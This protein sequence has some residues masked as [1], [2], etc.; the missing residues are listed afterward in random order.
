MRPS[1][2]I[3]SLLGT[4]YQK[5]AFFA[6][7]PSSGAFSS[8]TTS[9]PS[10]RLNSAVGSAPPP[11]P[12]TITSVTTST[13]RSPVTGVAA[14]RAGRVGAASAVVVGVWFKTTGTSLLSRD[15]RLDGA[16]RAGGSPAQAARSRAST[17]SRVT[18]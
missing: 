5:A 16:Q 2:R 12:T 1:A 9:L 18:G 8:S 7:P 3:G 15:V 13:G 4:Q 14:S 10:Q 6:V 17:P 11:P